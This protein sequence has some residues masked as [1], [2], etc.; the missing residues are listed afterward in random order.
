MKIS[1]VDERNGHLIFTY[2]VSVVGLNYQS[3]TIEQFDEAWRCAVED[4]L[5][6]NDQRPFYSFHILTN[7]DDL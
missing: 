6:E 1:I 4:R 2:P 3:T 7:K 5:V